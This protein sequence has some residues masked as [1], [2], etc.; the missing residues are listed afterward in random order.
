MALALESKAVVAQA[1]GAVALALATC[2]ALS[3][4]EWRSFLMTL[5]M[6]ALLGWVAFFAITLGLPDVPCAH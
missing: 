5:A 6:A 3:L 4:K 1:L 2:I